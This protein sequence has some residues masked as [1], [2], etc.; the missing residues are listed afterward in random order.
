M[1]NYCEHVSPLLTEKEAIRWLRLDET[2]VKNPRGSL[3]RYRELHGLR[4]MRIGR[5]MRYPIWELERFVQREF[6]R[7]T[8]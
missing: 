3:K 7:L 8:R 5:C 6:E 2:G 4:G 1:G